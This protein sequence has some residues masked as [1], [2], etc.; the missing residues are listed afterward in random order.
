MANRSIEL[1]RAVIKQPKTARKRLMKA[2][3]N[4]RGN[5]THTSEKLGVGRITLRRWINR[6]E[7]GE[8]VDDLR[9]TCREISRDAAN[10]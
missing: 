8:F 9:E 3:A 2:L 5:V 6:L 7:L 1:G 4:N 10:C